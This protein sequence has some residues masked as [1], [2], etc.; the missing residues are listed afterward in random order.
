MAQGYPG[1]CIGG[2]RA[3]HGPDEPRQSEVGTYPYGVGGPF[4]HQSLHRKMRWVPHTEHGVGM[5]G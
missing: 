3:L 2:G 5:V 4:G 1:V